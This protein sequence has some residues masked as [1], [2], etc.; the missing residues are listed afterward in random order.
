MS[1]RERVLVAG[2][3]ALMLVGDIVGAQDKPP[4]PI[5]AGPIQA[6]VKVNVAGKAVTKTAPLNV[7]VDPTADLL[8]AFRRVEDGE[9]PIEL[10]VQTLTPKSGEWTGLH[11]LLNIQ[12]GRAPIDP[13]SPHYIGSVE[14][15][16]ADEGEA[17]AFSFDLGQTIQRLKQARLWR[18]NR[19]L[20]VTLIGIP[21]KELR[22][23][24]TSGIV[25][26]QITISIPAA[27]S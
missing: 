20:M 14:F 12:K 3:T 26:K 24:K 10:I 22:D 18:P 11:V 6:R 16:G 2:V 25:V 4:A 5:Q 17:V 13:E 19:P 8:A 7:Q 1:C 23:Q 27:G 21:G 9:T 15:Y